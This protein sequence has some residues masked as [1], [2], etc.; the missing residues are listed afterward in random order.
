MKA[1]IYNKK[2]LV[3]VA[4]LWTIVVLMILV[5]VLG[6]KSRLDMKVSMARIEAVRCKWA[7]RAGAEKAVAVLNE[8]ETDND[9]LLDLWSDSDEDFNDIPL[10]NCLFNVRVID[11]AS[12]LNINYVTKDQLMGLTDMLEEIADAIIDWRDNNDNPSGLGV[13][14][15]YYE[16]LEFG[17]MAGNGPFRTIRELLLVKDVT[18]ELFYGEDTNFNGVLDYNE[19]D[20]DAT[21]PIDD[22]DT[23]LD[24]GWIAHLTCYTPAEGAG[25]SSGN[26]SSGN[27]SSDNQGSGNQS[28]DNQSSDNQDSQ[29]EDNQN[30]N[31]QNSSAQEYAKVNINTAS[32][33]VLTALLGGG[34]DAESA[35]LD[36]IAYRETAE[37]GIEAISELTSEGI[38]SNNVFSQIEN[39]ITTSSDVFTIYCIATA[40]RSGR[41]GAKLQTEVVVNRSSRPYEVLFSY[42]GTNN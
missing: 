28:S 22:G 21:P 39:Y 37:N 5:A 30:Q 27:Q 18:P 24:L 4:V 16:S 8:D 25:Q 40:D 15:G 12:K 11:E 19:R 23:E 13:E 36:I 31:N 42:Q 2:G 29:N 6:R 33:I 3:I 20:S 35:A 41:P 7:C 17:Y 26:Q 32:E 1:G 10:E 38:L 34:E 9:S 14:S